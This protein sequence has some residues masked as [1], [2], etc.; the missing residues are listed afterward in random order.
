[1]HCLCLPFLCYYVFQN[2]QSVMT[3]NQLDDLELSGNSSSFDSLV[4]LAGQLPI[5]KLYSME[6]YA[7]VNVMNMLIIPFLGFLYH[8]WMFIMIICTVCVC[9]FL[10]YYVFQNCQ[11]VMTQN[12]LDDLN[13]LVT[14]VLLIVSCSRWSIANQQVIQHGAL[15]SC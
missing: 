9:L 14:L 12:Q 13:C 11:S 5:S 2:C 3:Q 10:C 4:V 15:W 7:P 6:L 8:M 1:M